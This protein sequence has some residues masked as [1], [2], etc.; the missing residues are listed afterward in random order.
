MRTPAQQT[1]ENKC[2]AQKF[3][4]FRSHIALLNGFF[5]VKKRKT[6]RKK[7]KNASAQYAQIKRKK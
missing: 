1:V 7:I 5:S 4:E 6:K 3:S 2:N